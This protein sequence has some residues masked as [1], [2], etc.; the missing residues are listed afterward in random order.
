LPCRGSGFGLRVSGLG[1]GFKG[2][3]GK[4]LG[5]TDLRH[6]SHG[7][8]HRSKGQNHSRGFDPRGGPRVPAQTHALARLERSE[9][10]RGPEGGRGVRGARRRR[11]DTPFRR[12]C[13]NRRPLF[14]IKHPLF[15]CAM[16]RYALLV[17]CPSSPPPSGE[18][19]ILASL[20]GPTNPTLATVAR[21][22]AARPTAFEITRNQ[23]WKR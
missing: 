5:R 1:L 13:G 22:R 8:A 4:G 15:W 7:S 19:D 6:G 3:R 16:L 10:H 17:R 20:L 18:Q 9:I 12:R 11:T 2:S 21:N 14:L 23:V